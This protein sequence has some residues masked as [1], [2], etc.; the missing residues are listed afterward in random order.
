MYNHFVRDTFGKRKIVVI[1]HSDVKEFYYNILQK[2]EMK[3]N[4]L[5]NVHTQLHPAFDMAIRDG[6]IRTNPTDGVMSEIKKS[7]LWDAPKRH[8]LT[9]P[10]QKAFMNFLWEKESMLKA[11][12]TK[13]DGK[14]VTALLMAAVRAERFYDGAV[15]NFL[16]K[17][18]ICN[19]LERLKAID[20]AS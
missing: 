14:T 3:A 13:M 1:R 8:A 19:W 6:L 10:Q 9:I 18:A 7:K 2:Q 5:D 16:K 15:L 11:D 17:G 12:T 4:T 20:E